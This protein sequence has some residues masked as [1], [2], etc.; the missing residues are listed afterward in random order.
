MNE[1]TTEVKN[2]LEGKARDMLSQAQEMQIETEIQNSQ[3]ATFTASLKAE[4]K[5]RK[6]LLEPTKEALDASKKAYQGLVAQI[7]T[8][9]EEIT[10]L[11]TSKIGSF[12]QAENA[13]RAEL[14]AKEDV[15]VA[16]LQKK[17]DERVAKLQAKAEAKGKPAPDIIPQIIPQRIIATVSAPAG[18]TFT[19][20]WSA[21]VTDIKALC[22]GVVAGTV[23]ENM[24]MGNMPALNSY[25]KI[26]KVEGY[27]LPGVTGVKTMGTSQ[28]G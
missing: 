21:K 1:I 26:N 25:A 17:E 7:I 6:K 11:V 10:E 18:T 27:I 14:Q 9:L 16:E 22:A 20:Y 4:I 13:R 15:R 23:P 8:P 19:T 28:R 24:V 2:E 3:A 5:R 12:V